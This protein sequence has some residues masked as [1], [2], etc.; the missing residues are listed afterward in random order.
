MIDSL[1]VEL[2]KQQKDDDAEKEYCDSELDKAEDKKMG[3]AQSRSCRRLMRFHRISTS[4]GLRTSRCRS[5]G[6]CQGSLKI[7]GMLNLKSKKKV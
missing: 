4:T 7:A 1:T 2:G 6:K 5:R 3:L